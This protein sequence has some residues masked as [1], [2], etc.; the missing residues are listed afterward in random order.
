MRKLDIRGKRF[1]RLVVVEEVEQKNGRRHHRCLCDCGNELITE[2]GNLTAGHTK[3]CGCLATDLRRK[4]ITGKR[5]G[6][7]VAIKPTGKVDPNG[8]SVL[9]E[10][11]CDCGETVVIRATSLQHGVTMSCGCYQRDC[12]TKHNESKTK[13]YKRW[14][15]MV[16][17]CEF[18]EAY[19]DV[20]VCDEWL[21]TDGYENF[22]EWVL[23]QGFDHESIEGHHIHRIDDEP[24]YSPETCVILSEEEHA[25]VHRHGVFSGR[26]QTN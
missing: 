12:V 26:W 2:Q 8:G 1:G 15:G 7:L 24:L 17:R 3:S 4:D 25:A 11:R 10:C 5:F 13:L 18:K 9:W 23:Q 21:G 16:R 6:R 22:K 19:S 14:D 20:D